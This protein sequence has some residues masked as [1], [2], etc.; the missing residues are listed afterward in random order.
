M[1]NND[2]SVARDKSGQLWLF[3]GKPTRY[4]EWWTSE[5]TEFMKLPNDTYPNITWDDEPREVKL[6]MEHQ[7][8]T[9]WDLMDDKIKE[10]ESLDYDNWDGYDAMPVDK[11]SI[12]NLQCL[13]R[14]VGK[15]DFHDWQVA[16]GVNGDIYLN[17]KLDYPN[18][19]IIIR[20]DEFTYFIETGVLKGGTNKF[21]SQEV[22]EIMCWVQQLNETKE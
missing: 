6:I 1:S 2:L 16:P 3:S 15:W 20:P 7:D 18:A 10:L 4:S 8:K 9:P 21:N 12:K 5:N 13:F 17:Y 14:Y 22:Y 19:G 11:K